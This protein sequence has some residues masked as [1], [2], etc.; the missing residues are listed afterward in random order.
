MMAKKGVLKKKQKKLQTFAAQNK[1]KLR[2]YNI[3][4]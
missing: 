4:Q 3:T 2:T 1:A